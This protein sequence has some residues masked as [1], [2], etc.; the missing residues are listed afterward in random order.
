MNTDPLI[1][2]RTYKTS[3]ARLWKALTNP[4]E[5]KR[6]YF[7]LPG[8]KAEVGYE[9]R[10]LGGKDEHTQYLHICKVTEAIPEKKLAHTWTYDGY[11]GSSLLT[12]ELFEEGENIRLKLTHSGLHSFPKDVSDFA[13][14]NFVAGWAAILDQSLKGYLS[15]EVFT[16][17]TP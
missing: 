15:S 10:F 17:N 12:W 4:N 1:F 16:G 3:A 9:F 11:T 7:N 14:S 6:W 5:M 2:E 8:F 13:A